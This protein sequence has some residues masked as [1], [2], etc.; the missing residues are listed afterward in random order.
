M[1]RI[2]KI[3]TIKIDAKSELEMEAKLHVLRN[4]INFLNG[5]YRDGNIEW[6]VENLKKK[7]IK[8]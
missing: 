6:H 7:E 4:D 1:S 5:L 2:R 8:K 3:I